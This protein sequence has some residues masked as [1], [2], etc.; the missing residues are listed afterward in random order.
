MSSHLI[1][2]NDYFETK[3]LSTNLN[4][5]QITRTGRYK[6]SEEKITDK[7]F[8]SSIK[9]SPFLY[10]Q[11]KDSALFVVNIVSG[12]REVVKLFIAKADNGIWKIVF[13]EIMQVS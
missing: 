13:E 6:L 9:F 11:K 12:K 3:P 8:A 2:V 1:M 10:N 7:H 4:K 5:D